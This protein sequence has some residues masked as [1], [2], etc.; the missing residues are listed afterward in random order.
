M[1]VYRDELLAAERQGSA[2]HDAMEKWI[3]RAPG[4]PDTPG[5][6]LEGYARDLRESRER[7]RTLLS[8]HGNRDDIMQALANSEG[9]HRGLGLSIKDKPDL[10]P[11]PDEETE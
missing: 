7:I 8:E 4:A 11:D 10:E 5:A 1:S 9:Y 2:A 6:V 3:S